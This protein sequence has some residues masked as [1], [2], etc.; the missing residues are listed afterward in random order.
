MMTLPFDQD[1]V[2]RYITDG[3]LHNTKRRWAWFDNARR[4]TPALGTL[5]YLP[6]EIRRIIWKYIFHCRETPSADGLWEYDYT[7]GS[8]FNLSACMFFKPPFLLTQGNGP[9]KN[10][11]KQNPSKT[12]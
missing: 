6:V 7:L 3:I 1:L 12:S 9:L 10:I 5:Q 8:I 11:G 4:L 2:Q